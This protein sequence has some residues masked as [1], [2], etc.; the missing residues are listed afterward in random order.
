MRTSIRSPSAGNSARP[1]SNIRRFTPAGVART[2]GPSLRR[3][4]NRRGP[5][6]R[7]K[8]PQIQSTEVVE[9]TRPGP[10]HP[11]NAGNA[12]GEQVSGGGAVDPI[13]QGDATDVQS[14]TV[15]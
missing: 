13:P 4:A 7:Q 2:H 9:Q 8:P 1:R 5:T 10:L 3:A 11:A 14:P 15:T 6:S 12:L